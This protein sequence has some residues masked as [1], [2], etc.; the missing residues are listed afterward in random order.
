V[1]VWEQEAVFPGVAFLGLSHSLSLCCSMY[2]LTVGE[3]LT[4]SS[5]R[6][7][8]MKW[9]AAFAPYRCLSFAC[10]DEWLSLVGRPPRAG[11]QLFGASEQGSVIVSRTTIC[12]VFFLGF[13]AR[14]GSELI[15]FPLNNGQTFL[16]RQL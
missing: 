8:H 10:I 15:F 11:T 9:I 13:S 7:K 6:S 1:L 2:V 16:C 4:F 14:L 12:L 3:P 5:G